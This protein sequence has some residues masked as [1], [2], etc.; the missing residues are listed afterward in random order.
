MAV[1]AA[2]ARANQTRQQLEQRLRA[3]DPERSVGQF[4]QGAWEALRPQLNEAIGDLRGSQVGMGR[5]NTGFATGD[6][7]R[8]MT[9]AMSDLSSQIAQ[10]SVAAQ[11]LA[12]Q[13][14]GAWGSMY[15]Q[16]LNLLTTEREL[17]VARELARRQEREARRASIWGAVG[18]L[19]GAVLGGPVG[20]AIG[21][22]LGGK[23]GS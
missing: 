21:G 12:L 23:L 4:A 19:G 3:F 7:D 11:G 22:W 20:S 2:Q 18:T 6:E 15:G 9:R 1:S 17:E 16:D 8:L 13:G 5:L 10:Q 14:I